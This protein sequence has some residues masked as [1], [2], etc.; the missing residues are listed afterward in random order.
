M[1]ARHVVNIELGFTDGFFRIVELARVRQMGDVAGVDHES[2]F[3]G[4]F[5]HFADGFLQ[6]SER[7]G[8]GRFVEPV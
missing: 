3:G 8:I 6:G 5:A 2:G 4:E 1:L 7:V